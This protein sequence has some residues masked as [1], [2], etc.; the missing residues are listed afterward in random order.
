MRIDG[1][2]VSDAGVMD[3]PSGHTLPTK[4]E[5]GNIFLL[6]SDSTSRPTLY[7]SNGTTWNPAIASTDDLQN[8]VVRHYLVASDLLPADWAATT[9]ITRILNKPSTYI[10][11]HTTTATGT[12]SITWPTGRF[13]VAPIVTL[14]TIVPSI[15]G[16]QD[17]THVYTANVLTCTTTGMTAKVTRS[18]IGSVGVLLGGN[19]LISEPATVAVDIMVTATSPT[20]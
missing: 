12:L 11:K 19:I 20:D 1:M 10:K 2:S 4:H 3:I 18:L 7:A 17:A 16:S 14:Q 8:G 5:Q 6:V 13:A 15:S 9:G